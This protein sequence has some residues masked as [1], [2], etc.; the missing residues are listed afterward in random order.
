MMS[1]FVSLAADGGLWLWRFEPA[2]YDFGSDVIPSLLANSR[3][4]QY[5]GNVF[6]KAD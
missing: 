4:P 6:G 1:G 3:K 2:S 5:L